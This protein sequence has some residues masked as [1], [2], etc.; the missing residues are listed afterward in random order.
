MVNKPLLQAKVEQFKAD[1]EYVAHEVLLELNEQIIQQ[2]MSRGLRNKDLADRL[3]VSRS[4]ITRLL[5]GQPNLTI[6]SLAAI[7]LA[8]DCR[9]SVAMQ[10]QAS[11][12]LGRAKSVGRMEFQTEGEHGQGKKERHEEI[13][14]DTTSASATAA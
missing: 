3:N 8:L 9:L 10:S 2:M 11:A 14:T 4:Y 5:D 13:S 7:A 12:L 6:K 1:P